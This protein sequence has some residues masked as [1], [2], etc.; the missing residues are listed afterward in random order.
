MTRSAPHGDRSGVLVIVGAG[1]FGREVVD[2]VRAIND[3][4]GDLTIAGI[5]DDGAVE[6]GLLDAIGLPL[7]GTTDALE[8]LDHRYVIAVAAPAARRRIDRLATSAGRIAATLIHPSVTIGSR[9]TIGAGSVLCSHTSI[10]T[11]V[12]L[13]RHVQINPQTAIGHDVRAMDFVTVLPNATVSGKVVL[14]EGST[15]GAG[16]VVLQGLTVGRDAV[17]GAGSVVTRSVAE[18]TTVVGVPARPH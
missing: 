2:L 12:H 10:T 6:A 13:G 14:E 15:L 4:G 17:V 11:D 5:L 7:L 1:G 16:A 18:S 3:L 8:H 9:S